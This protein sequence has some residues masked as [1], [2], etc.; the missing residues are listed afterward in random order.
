M[1]KTIQLHCVKSINYVILMILEGVPFKILILKNRWNL[2]LISPWGCLC[3]RNML[4]NRLKTNFLY[5]R[6]PS[7][8]FYIVS[9][10]SLYSVYSN[11]GYFNTCGWPSDNIYSVKCFSPFLD[12]ILSVKDIGILW[13]YLKK[14]IRIHSNPSGDVHA[15]IVND[16]GS[17]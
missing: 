10:Y 1:C 15:W 17:E 14:K 4:W 7:S 9:A 6:I 12:R 3:K 16:S 8:A 11:Q 2:V 13:K 5:K